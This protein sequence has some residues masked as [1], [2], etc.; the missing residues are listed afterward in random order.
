MIAHRLTTVRTC[1][2]IFILEK[3]QMTAQGTFLELMEISPLFKSLAKS[4][5]L[6]EA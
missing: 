3:G 1:D 2:K 4:G 5:D 6:A